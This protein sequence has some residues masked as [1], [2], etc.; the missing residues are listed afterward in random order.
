MPIHAN[1]A[2]LELGI[3]FSLACVGLGAGGKFAETAFS[4]AGLRWM[5]LDAAIT[6]PAGSGLANEFSAAI[7]WPSPTA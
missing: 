4:S 6:I 2:F 1:T 7:F 3:I 5:M